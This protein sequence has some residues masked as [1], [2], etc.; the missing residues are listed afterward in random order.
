M[1]PTLK[2]E[3]VDDPK[4][5]IS[6]ATVP[7]MNN[8]YQPTP[9]PPQA[10]IIPKNGQNSSR[11]NLNP[12]TD[13]NVP[14]LN[15][16]KLSVSPSSLE[17]LTLSK[18]SMQLEDRAQITPNL[19]SLTFDRI[20]PK[21]WNEVVQDVRR[22]TD[23]NLVELRMIDSAFGD[24]GI[25]GAAEMPNLKKFWMSKSSLTKSMADTLLRVCSLF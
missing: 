14:E 3:P 4:K 12:K 17:A 21:E 9:T 10:F 11:N 18:V 19:K 6:P 7:A 13:R 8:K 15:Q 23:G 22:R 2:Q 5:S 24:D 25:A 1:R 16:Q 20:T